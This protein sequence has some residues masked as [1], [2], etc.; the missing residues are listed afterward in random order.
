[1]VR[2]GSVV[3]A[4]VANLSDYRVLRENAGDS[5]KDITVSP[6]RS[7]LKFRNLGLI[8]SKITFYVSI[9]RSHHRD[10]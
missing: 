4:P 1:M 7:T 3:S 6:A 2:S 8:F 9:D 5:L 10:N